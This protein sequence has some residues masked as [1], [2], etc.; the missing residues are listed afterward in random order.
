MPF[1]DQFLFGNMVYM[2]NNKNTISSYL[3]IENTQIGTYV[4]ICIITKQELS[5]QNIS[6]FSKTKTENLLQLIGI[7]KVILEFK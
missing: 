3:H 7:L 1:L 4:K 6:S 5:F 2:Y